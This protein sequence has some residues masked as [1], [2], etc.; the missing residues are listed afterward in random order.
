MAPLIMGNPD[1]P[2]LGVELTNSF[3]RMDPR[4]AQ[5]FA[6]TTFLSDNRADFPKVKVRSLILQ[7]SEDAI[8]P[9]CVGESVHRNLPGSEMV[10]LNA[11]GHCPNLSAPEETIAAIKRFL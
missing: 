2:E 11:T 1:R 10:L 5:V 7:C 6:R 9:Q 8:A 4:I 3:C